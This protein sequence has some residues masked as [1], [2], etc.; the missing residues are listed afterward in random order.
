MKLRANDFLDAARR[1]DDL[2]LTDAAIDEIFDRV[3]EM[4]CDGKYQEVD[5]LLASATCDGYSVDL[6]LA[7]LTITHA[8]KQ[9]LP[10]RHLFF[11]RVEQSILDRGEQS[12]RLLFGLA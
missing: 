8:A 7:L 6:L 5:D 2:G 1:M 10:H 12:D 4:L 11:A 3:N 9:Y